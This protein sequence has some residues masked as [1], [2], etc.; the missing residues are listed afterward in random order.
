MALLF[1][2]YITGVP[3]RALVRFP[4]GLGLVMEDE[5]SEL[6]CIRVTLNV[7]FILSCM[8]PDTTCIYSVLS[9]VCAK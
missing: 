6:S 2:F 4:L 1:H 5:P 7:S 8:L 3:E 9:R